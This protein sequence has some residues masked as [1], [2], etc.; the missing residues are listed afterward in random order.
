[1]W[2]SRE[3]EARIAAKVQREN[4]R[5]IWLKKFPSFEESIRAYYLTIGRAKAYAA[6]R[7]Y[8]DESNDDFE[9]IKGLDKYSELGE[10][11]VDIIKNV[12]SYNKLT[13]YD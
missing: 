4:N 7:R 8:R 5:T 1:M 11:Y 13:K 2:S 3:S 10:G 6:F 12:I 9:I